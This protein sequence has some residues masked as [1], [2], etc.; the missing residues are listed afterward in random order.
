M[1]IF[2]DKDLQIKLPL[3]IDSRMLLCANSGAGKSYAI[4]KLIEEAG[5]NVMSIILD[6][7]GEFKTLREK[8]DFLLIGQTGD[9][10][11]S[12]KAAHLLPAKLM[13]LNVSTIID[14]SDF[15]M[16]DRILYVKRFLEALMELPRKFWQPC[17]VIVDE[18]HM[19]C[20]QQEKQDSTHAVIDLMTRGRKRG[21][22]GILAT[23][24]IAK[25]HKDAAAEAN[26]YLVGRTS[27]DIDMNRSA[28]ILGFAT[29][30]D[31]LSLRTLAPGEFYFFDPRSDHGIEKVKI[32]KVQTT[33]PKVGMDLR[34]KITPPTEKIK[35]MLSKLNDLPKEAEQK[36]K[37]IEELQK[38][39]R[40][41][42]RESKKLPVARID[43]K[44]I[45]SA[46]KRGYVKAEKE[47]NQA[48][49]TIIRQHK[50]LHVRLRKIAE[51]AAVT[52]SVDISKLKPIKSI[53]DVK[54]TRHAGSYNPDDFPRKKEIIKVKGD[55]TLNRCERS[56]LSLLYNNPQREFKKTMVGLFAGYS[57]KS[58]GFNNAICHL[59]ALGLIKRHGIIITLSDN[60]DV[61]ELLGS[62][63]NLH[64]RFTIENWAHKLPRCESVIFQLLMQNPD[65]DFSKEEIGENTG[66]QSGSGG[67]NNAICRLNSLG[68]ILREGGKIK[69]N[70]EILE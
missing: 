13:E 47:N 49:Q 63:V 9:V 54:I 35:A 70:S 8:Y 65:S 3:L 40:E 5:S 12:I 33:H 24:R 41:L 22:C 31:K 52:G 42:H 55:I 57:H 11:I 18:A 7:E 44:Q 37:T 61:A 4:R 69:L 23:Q 28:E 26:F 30:V 50:D 39:V 27:L 15:K 58:G 68:L 59:N 2:E 10:P 45:E 16:H 17:L 51:L 34:G 6:V 66:Y 20:G 19:Y 53:P 46:E 25:L 56:I 36:A 1:K 32:A 60:G 21:Y 38:Q 67:F 62:D 14:I 64:E 48:I 29:K 43:E